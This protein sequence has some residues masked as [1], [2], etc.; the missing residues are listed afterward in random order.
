MGKIIL[1]I[2]T[3]AMLASLDSLFHG[4]THAGAS[5]HSCSHAAPPYTA[6][7]DPCMNWLR[8]SIYSHAEC[9]TSHAQWQ[10]GAGR[11]GRC[12]LQ[13]HLSTTSHFDFPS[14]S[15]HSKGT[16]C[17]HV[18]R[19]TKRHAVLASLTTSTAAAAAQAGG[20]GGRA[21]SGGAST[22]TARVSDRHRALVGLV[23][24]PW[25]VWGLSIVTEADEKLP[26]KQTHIMGMQQTYNSTAATLRCYVV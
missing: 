21:G 3:H 24:P 16:S 6:V 8:C 20:A 11:G 10:G 19:G 22:A 26:N 12:S 15:R 23:P 14:P 2:C 9:S 4:Y 5:G 7:H 17:G 18:Q 1:S 25:C 13:F